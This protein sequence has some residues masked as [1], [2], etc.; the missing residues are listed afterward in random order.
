MVT[1]NDQTIDGKETPVKQRNKCLSFLINNWFMLSTILGVIAGFAIAFG[2][3]TA[4][5]DATTIT[6][7]TMPGDIYLR[8]LQLT[9][10]PLITS[11]VLVVMASLEPKKNGAVSIVGIL[12]IIITCLVGTL[13]GTAC[14][15]LIKPGSYGLLTSN[16]S[17]KILV[18]SGLTASDIFKDIFFNFF[19]D[20]IIGVTIFQ[21]RTEVINLTTMEKVGNPLKGGTNLIGVLFCA[22]IFGAA[23]NA[24]GEIAKPMVQF[25]EAVSATVTK[26]MGIFLLLTPIGVCSMVAGS[27][28]GREDVKSDF[29]QLGLFV[30]TVITGL[31]ILTI[32][33]FLVFFISSGKNPFR[34]L[35]YS[36][37]SSLIGFAASTPIV[38]IGEM[39]VGSDAYGCDKMISRLLIPIGVAMKGDG[40]AVFIASACVFIAQQTGVELD[41]GKV[42]LIILLTFVSS[43]AVPNIPSSSIVL[44]VTILSSV[45]VPSDKAAILFATDWLLDRCRS[46]VIPIT[47]LCGI[48]TTEEICRRLKGR[49]TDGEEKN[50]LDGEEDSQVSVSNAGTV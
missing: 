24:V 15:C 18:G 41:A 20:N 3:R 13:I 48:A 44:I 11:N 34:I 14:S 23:A 32:L 6:W 29:I 22:L 50:D 43:L 39:Y 1:A 7:I 19:P 2:A 28:L 16:G 30:V 10:L 36:L 27:V 17:N 9:I 26:L 12:Y 40:P 8:I 42:I 31:S 33:T 38:A 47:I 49:S 37:Q 4:K 46:G 35:K 25:F 45:G 21:Y 5:L